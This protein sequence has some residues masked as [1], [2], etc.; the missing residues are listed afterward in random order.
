MEVN[1]A[2]GHFAD[3]DA[4]AAQI[5]QDGDRHAGLCTDVTDSRHTRAQGVVPGVGKS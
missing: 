5:A 1:G 4:R 3:P 2:T